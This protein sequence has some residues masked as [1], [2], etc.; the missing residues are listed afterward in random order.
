MERVVAGDWSLSVTSEK[1]NDDTSLTDHIQ[2]Y[3]RQIR[4]TDS[5]VKS[6]TNQLQYNLKTGT[7]PASP[8]PKS[9]SSAQLAWCFLCR[10]LYNTA[11]VGF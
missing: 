8:C 11:D 6:D 7:C 10:F 4:E 1:P 2:S 5:R 9:D 3:L